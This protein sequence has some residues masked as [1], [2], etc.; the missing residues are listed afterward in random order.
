MHTVRRHGKLGA[1]GLTLF[2]TVLVLAVFRH[3]TRL[4]GALTGEAHDTVEDERG[5]RRSLFFRPAQQV[6]VVKPCLEQVS[7]LPPEIPEDCALGNI[8]RI[9]ADWEHISGYVK[10]CDFQARM[11]TRSNS[12]KS[13]GIVIPSA[14]HT[15]FA[16]TWVV[17]TILRDTLGCQ[18]PIEVVYNGQEELDVTLAE[19]LKVQTS[20]L[21][22]LCSL[23]ILCD[24][25]F[26]A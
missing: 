26:H 11:K 2:S 7:T 9:T 1:K 20:F 4:N 12:A 3:V 23:I 22:H 24:S 21:Q 17:V 6:P 10:S 19:R 25:K 16:H 18:L 14:G 15:M 5:G 8:K 13:R